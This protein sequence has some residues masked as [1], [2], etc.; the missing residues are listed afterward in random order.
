MSGTD[1]ETIELVY[2]LT[3]D[4]GFQVLESCTSCYL[5]DEQALSIKANMSNIVVKFE[6]DKAWGFIRPVSIN[7]YEVLS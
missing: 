1:T 2:S 6:I 7:G 4:Q 3:L 5:N